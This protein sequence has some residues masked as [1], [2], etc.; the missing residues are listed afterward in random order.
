VSGTTLFYR[1]S[2][3]GTFTVNATGA[4][5]PETGI[6][7]GNAGYS[8]TALGGFLDGEQSIARNPA[9]RDSAIPVSCS[10]A[11]ANDHFEAVVAHV[12]RLCGSLHTVTQ[13]CH[14][15]ILQ[16][17]PRLLEWKFFARNDFFFRAAKIDLCHNK[18]SR[19]IYCRFQF[20]RSASPSRQTISFNELLITVSSPLSRTY[21]RIDSRLH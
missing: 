14:D 18:F 2:A 15:F 1:P 19:F 20:S 21:L 10:F 17:I 3:S 11:L 8:F 13:H 9:I 16:N 4:S 7:A 5:D 12:Q 6:K